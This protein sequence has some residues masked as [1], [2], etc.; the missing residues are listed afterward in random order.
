MA[1]SAEGS[2]GRAPAGR[3]RGDRDEERRCAQPLAAEGI[4]HLLGDRAHLRR[5]D[6]GD[7]RAAEAP[8]DHPATEGAGQHGGVHGDVATASITVNSIPKVVRAPA[9]LQTMKSMELPSFFCGK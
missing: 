8:A 7:G 6:E 5:A 4:G 1:G 9:G 2:S 3:R